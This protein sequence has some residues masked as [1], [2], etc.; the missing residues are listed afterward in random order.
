MNA[1]PT[2][3]DFTRQTRSIAPAVPD[4]TNAQD[5][6]TVS[7]TDNSDDPSA[8]VAFC[9]KIVLIVFSFVGMIANGAT[10][11]ALIFAKQVLVVLLSFPRTYREKLV[12]K[13]RHA[14]V[15]NG[16]GQY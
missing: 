2:L 12:Q 1:T 13:E 16:G 7:A 9:F 3:S 15:Y 11:M 5:V 6:T 14:T 8:V 10:L 4:V